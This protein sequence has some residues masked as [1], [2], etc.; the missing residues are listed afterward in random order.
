[1]FAAL[2]LIF[3]VVGVDA[4]GYSLTALAFGVAA[5]NA[6]TGLCLVHGLPADP[7]AAIG[8]VMVTVV[9]VSRPR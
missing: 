2:A 1:V 5:L 6:S 8:D 4:V 7:P 3:F 9:P